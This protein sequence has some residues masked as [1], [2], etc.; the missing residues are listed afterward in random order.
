MSRKDQIIALATSQGLIRTK[1]IGN[2][3][4]P[5]T[6]IYRLCRAGILQKIGNGLYALA[7]AKFSEHIAL[8][9]VAKRVPQAV[10]SLLSAL[11]FHQ[12]TPQ[13]PH[14]VW[15]TV[16]KGAWKPDIGFPPLSITYVSGPALHFGIQEHIIDGVLVRIYSPAKTIAD[17]FKFRNK[18]GLRVAI[19]ALKELHR[20]RLAT[21]D[22]VFEAAA[23][24][25]VDKIIRPYVEAI[26]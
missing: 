18:I 3:G 2:A 7:D 11:N 19:Q 17:C 22:E 13:L 21:V 12:L 8:A 1:D 16:A 6:Y 4:I 24:C 5:R 15:I 14:E 25:R 20:T 9:E 26:L 23:I 10:V